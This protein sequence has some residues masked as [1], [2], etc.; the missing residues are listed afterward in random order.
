MSATSLQHADAWAAVEVIVHAERDLVVPAVEMRLEAHDPALARLR[1]R[2]PHRELRRFRARRREPHALDRGHHVADQP[3]P[4]DF[5]LVRRGE[6][7]ALPELLL[8]RL[9]H[10]GMLVPEEQRPVAAV[11]ID[12]LVAVDVPLARAAARSP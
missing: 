1:A 10:F 9:Q 12:V 11:V 2:K 4:L 3:R 5:E 7:H 8:D 6:M